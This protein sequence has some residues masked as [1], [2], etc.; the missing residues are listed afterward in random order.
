MEEKEVILC[1]KQGDLAGLE[2]LVRRYYYQALHTSYLIVRD[3]Y[4]AEDVVQTFF[5]DLPKKIHRFDENLP[6]RPWMMK[7]VV[8]ASIN[9][10]HGNRRF[11]SLDQIDEYTGGEWI[12][13]LDD[14]PSPEDQVITAEMRQEVWDML[15]KLNPSQRAAIVMRYYLELNEGEMVLTLNKPR[16]SI[17]WWLHSAKRRLQQLFQDDERSKTISKDVN[18]ELDER[19]RETGYE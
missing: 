9:V 1:L 13:F 2:F 7:C 3:R 18:V 10:F 15:G 6:F 17:K 14:R 8:N 16:S 19:S 5:L 4:L 11:V 12:G